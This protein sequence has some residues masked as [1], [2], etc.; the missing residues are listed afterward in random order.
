MT[1]F[2]RFGLICAA[3]AM[4]LCMGSVFAQELPPQGTDPIEETHILKCLAKPDGGYYCVRVYTGDS[5]I[6]PADIDLAQV[7]AAER[8]ALTDE[9]TE[10]RSFKCG[11]T[12]HCEIIGRNPYTGEVYVECRCG[13]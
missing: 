11:L 8:V 9:P 4:A 1:R 5:L 6:D 12:A 10:V 7:L 13:S 2:Q 3:A